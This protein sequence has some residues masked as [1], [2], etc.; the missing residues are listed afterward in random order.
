MKL[1]KYSQILKRK[2]CSIKALTPMIKKQV[3]VVCQ[4]ISILMRSFKCSLEKG[5]G[6]MLLH[7][8]SK[9]T[10]LGPLVVFQATLA[11][12]PNNLVKAAEKQ[13]INHF[14][15]N[16]VAEKRRLNFGNPI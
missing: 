15:S 2:E 11:V 8:V 3:L 6:M 7:L 16:S 4:L 13:E 9:M 12:F 1:I 10:S 5:V 14:N